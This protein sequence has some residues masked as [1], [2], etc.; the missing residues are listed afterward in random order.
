MKKLAG[1]LMIIG[2][3]IIF[4]TAGSSD[5]GTVTHE[6]LRLMVGL[7]LFVTGFLKGEMWNG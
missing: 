7:A 2:M 1:I 6:G 5:M 4:G 3:V